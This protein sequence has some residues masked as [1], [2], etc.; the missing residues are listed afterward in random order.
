[1]RE[2]AVGETVEGVS[3]AVPA[4][5]VR[6]TFGEEE[7]VVG[8]VVS[9]VL[10]GVLGGLGAR[11]GPATLHVRTKHPD[12]TI[13]IARDMTGGAI[14]GDSGEGGRDARARL[15]DTRAETIGEETF[16]ARN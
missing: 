8:G 13:G 10:G 15:M 14:N 9:G 7:R 6:G 3:F 5:R 12:V 11:T 2:K 16:L 4:G 1:M